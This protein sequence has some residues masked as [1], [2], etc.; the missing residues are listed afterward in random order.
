MVSN[1]DFRKKNKDYLFAI[2]ESED[3]YDLFKFLNYPK[4]TIFDS[5]CVKKIKESF[6]KLAK[7][8]VKGC[9]GEM[10]IDP[11]KPIREQESKPLP[12][13]VELD[14]IIFDELGLTKE[15]RKE[16]Y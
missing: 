12:D 7:R 13:R 14:N 15:E 3:V 6:T 8:E 1:S 16:V 5:S 2:K 9:F 11:S 4:E 10:G